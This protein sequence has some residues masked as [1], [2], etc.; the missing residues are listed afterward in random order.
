MQLLY[1]L[2]ISFDSFSFMSEPERSAM[3]ARDVGST[4]PFGGEPVTAYLAVPSEKR[5]DSVIRATHVTTE[6]APK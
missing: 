5:E 2:L 4:V 1:L 3:Q 6:K